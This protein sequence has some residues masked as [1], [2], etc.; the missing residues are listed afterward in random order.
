MG[1]CAILSNVEEVIEQKPA[2]KENRR[3]QWQDDKYLILFYASEAMSMDLCYSHIRD[4]DRCAIY[5][6]FICISE[7]DSIGGLQVRIHLGAKNIT[8]QFWRGWCHC[9]HI[10]S[11]AGYKTR[12]PLFLI[13]MIESIY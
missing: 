2:E 8:F 12:T 10:V 6:H 13:V 11:N 7:N 3:E 4:G 9:R 1:L 5:A